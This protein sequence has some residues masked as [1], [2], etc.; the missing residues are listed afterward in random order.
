MTPKKVFLVAFADDNVL[1]EALGRYLAAFPEVK[2][3]SGRYTANDDGSFTPFVADG[4]QIVERPK[5]EPPV[6]TPPAPE[7]MPAGVD[8]YDVFVEHNGENPHPDPNMR[9]QCVP[10][11]RVT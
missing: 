8:D 7:Q 3:V 5:V 2:C 10:C 11:K 6:A 1:V 4:P 9:C